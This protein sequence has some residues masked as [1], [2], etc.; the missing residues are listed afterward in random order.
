MVV[1]FEE[2]QANLK[3][4]CYLLRAGIK[5]VVDA[6]SAAS[7]PGGR[8]GMAEL[9]ATTTGSLPDGSRAFLAA[10]RHRKPP[11]ADGLEP[12]FPEVAQVSNSSSRFV[13]FLPVATRTFA[14]CFGYGNA[15]L[16]A[17]AIDPNFG[18]RYAARTFDSDAIFELDSRRISA[19]ARSQSVQALAGVR[20]ADLDVPLLG[21]FIR[22]LSG[23]LDK[24]ASAKVDGIS[25]V[26]AGD[27]VGFRSV[28]DL[29]AVQAVL[30]TMLNVT[31]SEDPKGEFEFVDALEPLRATDDRV[32]N[33][34][35]SLCSELNARAAGKSENP[36]VLL[37]LVPPE[38]P[39]VDVL[40]VVRVVLG[41]DS[42]DLAD[43]SVESLIAV[44]KAKKIRVSRSSLKSIKLA[45]VDEQGQD[46]PSAPLK[47][48]LV[49][50]SQASEAR[51]ILT[52]GKWFGLNETFA[53]Q[54]DA[55][56]KTIPD[57]TASL[58][59]PEW[60]ANLTDEGDYNEL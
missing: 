3:L 12:Y 46:G 20:L 29:T 45:L 11:W 44:L 22:K 23:K 13:L 38:S 32:K 14:I 2:T 60:P 31:Q 7:R 51:Y 30:K 5:D 58:S 42:E 50:E 17:T 57:D 19:S 37:S 18:L 9:A 8:D 39:S 49:F 34:E 26:V 4:T 33:L 24:G 54:L 43:F 48:W 59:L 6:L 52:L 21:E 56:L 27:G 55:D 47:S 25:A 1:E 36:D 41:D 16:S 35:I 28:V 53:A 10:N 15:S 40:D